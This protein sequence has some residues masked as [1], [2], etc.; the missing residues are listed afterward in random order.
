MRIRG[1]CAGTVH[2]AIPRANVFCQ[3]VRKS[4]GKISEGRRSE[5]FALRFPPPVCVCL[6][7]L[8]LANPRASVLCQRVC[9]CVL[10]VCAVVA[11]TG[12]VFF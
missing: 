9:G 7:T 8:R 4:C 10:N 5:T 3:C 11:T 6:R 1:F 2:Q 12:P